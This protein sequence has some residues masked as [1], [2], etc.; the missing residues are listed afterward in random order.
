MNCDGCRVGLTDAT[1]SF[2]VFPRA[3]DPEYRCKRCRRKSRCPWC[4]RLVGRLVLLPSS[5][6]QVCERCN[7][8]VNGRAA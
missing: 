5:I 2:L 3:S 6:D 1:G 4:R 7:A 8:R